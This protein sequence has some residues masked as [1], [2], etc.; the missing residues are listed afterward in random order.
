MTQSGRVLMHLCPLKFHDAVP[1]H[2]DP[3]CALSN[4]EEDHDAG[5]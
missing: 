4:I 3:D 5:P 1:H 2:G